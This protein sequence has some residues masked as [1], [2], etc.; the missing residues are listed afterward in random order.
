MQQISRR[1]V[2][3]ILSVLILFVNPLNAV[4]A[5][6]IGPNLKC[7]HLGQTVIWRNKKYTCIK[8]GKKLVWNKGISIPKPKA[9]G[10]NATKTPVP[11]NTPRPIYSPELEEYVVAKSLDVRLNQPMTVNNPSLNFPSRGYIVVRRESGIIVFNNRCTHEGAEVEVS[12]GKLI[13]FRH[14]SYFDSASGT[15]LSGP[16]LRNLAQIP[17]FERDGTVFVIDAH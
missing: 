8:S 2:L 10:I 17:V 16:A 9:S 7:T 4:A 14:L 5:T 12:D 1:Q 6:P 15:P 13:C 3:K 11:S